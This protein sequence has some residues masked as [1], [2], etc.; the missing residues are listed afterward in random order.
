M[1]EGVRSWGAKAHDTGL[2]C[3]GF[4]VPIDQFNH[5]SGLQS[6]KTCVVP[7]GH[8]SSLASVPEFS[9]S[10]CCAFF[11]SVFVYGLIELTK[12]LENFLWW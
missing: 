1:G 5:L 4:R 10:V 6:A 2:A 3:C 11:F 12:L 9:P 7:P 8:V